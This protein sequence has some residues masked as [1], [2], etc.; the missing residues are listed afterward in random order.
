[1]TNIAALKTIGSETM[2]S[3]HLCKKTNIN[4]NNT[5]AQRIPPSPSNIVEKSANN[6]DIVL[7]NF[8]KRR[9]NQSN[10]NRLFQKEGFGELFISVNNRGKL[11]ARY[12]IIPA[13]ISVTGPIIHPDN[14]ISE[15]MGNS[16][17]PMNR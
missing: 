10:E 13:I 12:K 16:H 3:D 1:V 11:K 8:H 14:D 5:N 7:N 4:K 6:L 9:Y 17:Q 15:K 2:D